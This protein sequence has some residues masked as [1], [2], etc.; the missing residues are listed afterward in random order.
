[1]ADQQNTGFGFRIRPL[2][3]VG[4]GPENR[5][6]QRPAAEEKETAAPADRVEPSSEPA[7]KDIPFAHTA[8]RFQGSGA[9]LSFIGAVAAA[10]I[11]SEARARRGPNALWWVEIPASWEKVSSMAASAGGMAFAG[12]GA[13][14]VAIPA[15]GSSPNMPKKPKKGKAGALTLLSSKGAESLAL[16]DWPEAGLAD[17]VTAAPIRPARPENLREVV[18]L[19]P[20]VLA[21]GIVKRALLLGFSAQIQPAQR[22]PLSGGPV[23]SASLVRIAWKQ[24]RTPRAFI[25]AITRLPYTA[26]ARAVDAAGLEKNRRDAL[27]A[28]VRFALPLAASLAA[29]LV[30]QGEKWLLGGPEVGHWRIK[31]TGDPMDAGELIQ[32]P[33]PSPAS[34]PDLPETLPKADLPLH[35]IPRTP[36]PGFPDAVLLDDRELPWLRDCFI[37]K[38]LAEIA[39]LIPGPNRHLLAAPGGLPDIPPFGIPPFGI[40]LRRVGPGGL[41]LQEGRAFYPPLPESARAKAFPCAE[42]EIIAVASDSP[43]GEI[44]A[45]RFRLD[46]MIPLWTLWLCDPPKVAEGMQGEA[47]ARIRKLAKTLQPIEKPKRMQKTIGLAGPGRKAPPDRERLREEAL[48]LAKQ[49]QYAEAA[50]RMEAA[51][52]MAAAGRLY[53]R[54]AGQK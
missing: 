40:P 44:Q 14:W 38:P 37:G 15:D 3:P 12:E 20:G 54:A 50:R 10:G 49:G 30:P 31:T 42:E 27:L 52:D 36:A 21:S 5:E 23:S 24:N 26:V 39:Y 33:E 47:A 29:T 4:A 8:G 32:L 7:G 13:V 1:M 28:D 16:D 51:G 25:R 2:P 19:T 53:E 9:A 6:T 17:L 11:A 45:R 43:D 34:A 41:H 35:L 22:S 18:V 48:R 46:R